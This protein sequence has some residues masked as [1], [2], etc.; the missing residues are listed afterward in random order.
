MK[1][2]EKN[3]EMYFV[4]GALFFPNGLKEYYPALNNLSKIWLYF[5]MVVLVWTI[6]DALHERRAIVGKNLLVVVFYFLL[7][8]VE[9]IVNI[10]K[11]NEGLQKLFVLPAICLYIGLLNK[12]GL[13]NFIIVAAN[14]L[15]G[16]LFLNCT[17]FSPCVLNIILQ[18]EYIPLIQ[19][20]GHVQIAT[21]IGCLG[22]FLASLL[23]ANN[24][25]KKARILI[26]LSS[27]TIVLSKTLAGAGAVVII[28]IAYI[29]KQSLHKAICNINHRMIFNIM[30]IINIGII[31]AVLKYHI[32]FGARY[33]VWIMVVDSLKDCYMCGYGVFGKR[34]FPFWDN[35]K[36]G[37]G[38]NYAHNVLLQTLLDGG[39]VL[40][41]A[42]IL[43]FNLILKDFK[44]SNMSN[45]KYWG[46]I[47]L[48]TFMTNCVCD[49]PTEHVYIWIFLMLLIRLEE[50]S[51]II[52]G[53]RIRMKKRENIICS[54]CYI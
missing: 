32:D 41:A 4:L 20:I 28:L 21:S 5:A 43:M 33:A 50:I 17:V 35:I 30:F 18:Q 40:T 16:V 49:V 37:I 1:I 42:F 13:I 27:L 34:I 23:Y 52:V 7:V 14:V 51:D 36:S 12:K 15:M 44:R 24:Y 11:I 9:T 47:L 54:D 26:A 53:S 8:I 2:R 19:F 3:L 45:I 6:T 29:F 48:F 38:M 31:Y 46:N 22:F 25:R 10:G 39:I